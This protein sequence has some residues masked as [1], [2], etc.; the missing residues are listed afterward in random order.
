MGELER[1]F[2]V[3]AGREGL[4][5]S[6]CEV[7]GQSAERLRGFEIRVAMPPDFQAITAVTEEAFG[8]PIEAQLVRL[9]HGSSNFVR[10]LSLVAEKDGEVIGHVMLS[11]A[12]LEERDS[13]HRVLTLSPV[14]V[15]P[16]AQRKGVG[17]T[18]INS[19]LRRA[20]ERGEPMVIL[21]GSPKYYGRLGFQDGRAFGVIFDL[22]DWAPPNAGQIYKLTHYDPT[23]KGKVHYPAAFAATEELRTRLENKSRGAS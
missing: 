15:A 18:L 3:E 13:R 7:V 20:D 6:S 19:A 12:E 11:Y 16:K 1:G 23:I 10:D 14:S 8:S 21:E 5:A 22:P 4:D 9:I 2:D 17:S